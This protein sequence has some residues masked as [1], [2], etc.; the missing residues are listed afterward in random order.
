MAKKTYP[1]TRSCEGR[2]SVIHLTE[3]DEATHHGSNNR[4]GVREKVLRRNKSLASHA[5]NT[6][7][8]AKARLRKSM[9]TSAKKHGQYPDETQQR[10]KNSNERLIMKSE[11]ARCAKPGA[12]ILQR[13]GRFVPSDTRYTPISPF[14]AS[15]ALYV[16]P[17]GTE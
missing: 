5:D 17:G 13:Y 6:W 12:R 14:G 16:S 11:P 9:L 2:V 10:E 1:N 4:D 7:L 15:I 8:K 3:K